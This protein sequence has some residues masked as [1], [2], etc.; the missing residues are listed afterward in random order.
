MILET[1]QQTP[2]PLIYYSPFRQKHVRYLDLSGC[3][4]QQE[5]FYNEKDD[6]EYQLNSSTNR[7]KDFINNSFRINENSSPLSPLSLSSQSP[8]STS[9]QPQSSSFL[10]ENSFNKYSY[11]NDMTDYSSDEE[12]EESND[13]GKCVTNYNSQECSVSPK[14]EIQDGYNM[15]ATYILEKCQKELNDLNERYKPFISIEQI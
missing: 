10:D 2:S 5:L 12:D 3:P 7:I 14:L 11:P 1:T 9:S 6:P 13:D 4:N 8:L 15:E